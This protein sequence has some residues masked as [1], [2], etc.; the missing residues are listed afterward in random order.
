[1]VSTKKMSK[2]NHE[3]LYL[4][5]VC[6]GIAAYCII[7]FHYRIFYN[8]A[9][10]TTSFVKNEQPF[11]NILFSAYEFG[12]ISVQFFF[13]ISGFVF[14][15][16]YL[17][18]IS[19]KKISFKEF[20]ILRFSRLYPLHF[21]TLNIVLILYLTFKLLD[22]ELFSFSEINIKHYILNILLISSWGF[23]NQA[24][25]NTPSWSISIEVLLYMLFFFVAKINVK[26]F[27]S[28]TFLILFGI[29]IFYFNKLIGYGI[30]CFFIGAFTYLVIVKINNYKIKKKNIIF[31]FS[32]IF[33]IAIFFIKNYKITEIHFKILMLTIIFPTL[34]IILFFYQQINKKIGEKISLIGDI[35]YSLYLIHLPIQILIFGILQ[36]NN[37]K[38]DFNSKIYFLSYIITVTAISF[39]S[40]F[41]FEKSI[42]K[43]FRKN[44]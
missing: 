7:I 8:P 16:L 24:S 27:Y 25:F 44:I 26:I 1:M 37:I 34:I 33:I 2:K 43:F 12:W 5:D 11:H 30:F 29:F 17:K 10:N 28:T 13:T 9:I 19:N 23:E 4:I 6:R 20:F 14:Y 15:Y 22:L 3:R 21:V 41:Y 38:L 32:I 42:Q 40:Y 31:L 39:L 18:Q 36:F 35:S